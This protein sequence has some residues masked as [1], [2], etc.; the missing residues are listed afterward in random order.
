MRRQN[1]LTVFETA[2]AGLVKVKALMFFASALLQTKFIEDPTCPTAWTD[3]VVI[4][5]NP[6]FIEGL[7]VPTAKFV[8]I[9]ELMHILL[10]HGL[11]RGSRDPERWNKAC[12]YAINIMLKKLGFSI[13]KWALIEA[14]YDGMSAEQIYAAREQEESKKGKGQGKGQGQGEGKGVNLSPGKGQ[15]QASRATSPSK[16]KAGWVVICVRCL[17]LRQSRQRRSITRSARHWREPPP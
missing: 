5:Y 2:R 16:P 10:K 7:D 1:Q 15:A 14:K 3:M 8:I 9:H 11:R 6:E 12:D 4:G 13:W 17:P